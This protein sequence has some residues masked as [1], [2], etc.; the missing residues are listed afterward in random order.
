MVCPRCHGTGQG[1]YQW[2][3]TDGASF[4]GVRP[5]SLCNGTGRVR[6]IK[7]VYRQRRVCETCHGTGKV[8]AD[9]QANSWLRLRKPIEIPCST[10]RGKGWYMPVSEPEFVDFFEP[11]K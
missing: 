5:C 1:Y 3:Y 9:P 4:G 10:C 8:R 11:E 6:H 7:R 2:D